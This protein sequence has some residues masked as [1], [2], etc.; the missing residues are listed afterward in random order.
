MFI[1]R[2]AER[3]RSDFLLPDSY[4]GQEI[5]NLIVSPLRKCSVVPVH[6]LSHE[7]QV[8]VGLVSLVDPKRIGRL[9]LE[10]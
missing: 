1:N 7:D 10:G 5:A 2:V 6:G 3:N 8:R 9:V 4:S